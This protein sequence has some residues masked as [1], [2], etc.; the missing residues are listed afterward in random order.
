MERERKKRCVSTC[1]KRP[2]S[3]CDSETL[4]RY[5]DGAKR[6]YCRLK[7]TYKFNSDCE[8]V[9]KPVKEARRKPLL[10]RTQAIL[11]RMAKSEEKLRELEA[12]ERL[13][14]PESLLKKSSSKVSEEKLKE[15]RERMQKANATRKIKKFMQKHKNKRL[16]RAE[17]LKQATQSVLKE[18]SQPTESEEEAEKIKEFNERLKKANATRKIKKFMRKHQNKRRA[19]FLKSICSDSGVCMAFGKESSRILKHFNNFSNFD[20]LSKPAKTIGNVSS[21]GFVK[22]LT[23]ERD[24]YVA[25][26]ILKSSANNMSDNL[27]Y[28]T[29]VGMRVNDFGLKYSCFVETYGAYR[30][31]LDH[32]YEEMKR[33]KETGVNFLRIGVAN[34]E[35]EDETNDLPKVM[36]MACEKP[37]QI[38]VMIQHLKDAVSLYDKLHSLHKSV[39]VS[40]E[41]LY[42]LYQIYMPLAHLGDNFTHYDLHTSNVLLYEPVKGSYIEYN[43]HIKT[44]FDERLIKFKSSYI[45]KIIDYGRCYVNFGNPGDNPRMD[46]QSFYDEAICAEAKCNP[47]CGYFKG[48]GWFDYKPSEM[49][50]NSHI[51]SQIPNVSHDLRLLY[52]LQKYADATKSD[53]NFWN[54]SNGMGMLV[55]LSKIQYGVDVE[56]SAAKKALLIGNPHFPVYSG[57]KENKTSGLNSYGLIDKVNN[58][59]DAYI[60]LEIMINSSINQTY[61]DSFYLSDSKLGELHIY[62]D[63]TPMKYIPA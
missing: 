9:L 59:K 18:S 50:F 53:P 12:E 58:V 43:Y 35:L 55:F 10:K 5:T 21:N 42:V 28:E 40:R 20:L 2:K 56:L 3:D 19:L 51:S 61:N 54:T 4:C 37:T 26:T 57:T 17:A 52:M 48:F 47:S 44:E 29:I 41:L 25:N 1:R 11:A 45:A 8:P 22:E 15:F 16:A 63:G 60:G 46:S 36:E 30:Y 13:I 31:N 34:L 23:Y 38:A 49:K 14:A 32:V 7:Y 39:F 6:K 33:H 24:G 62:S 27:I